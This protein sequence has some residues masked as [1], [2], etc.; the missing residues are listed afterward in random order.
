MASK[1][2]K[3]LIP[4]NTI[5]LYGME[6]GVIETFDLLRP[7]VKPH[8][9][10][11]HTTQRLSLP[12][13]AEVNG[14]R[15]DHSFFADFADWPRIERP[16][17]LLHAF[18]LLLTMIRGNLDVLR[19]SLQ[20]DVIYL[21]GIQYFYFAVLALFFHRFRRKKVIFHFHD[22]INYS[23]RRLRFASWFVTSFVH[24]SNLSLEVVTELNPFIAK[25][26]NTI[27]PYPVRT[28]YLLSSNGAF[29]FFRGRD[30]IIFLGQVSKHKGVDILLKAFDLLSKSHRNVTLHLVGGCDDPEMLA[31]LEAASPENECQIRYWG[32][33]AD[34]LDLLKMSDVYVHPSPPSRFHESFGL[35]VVEAMSVGVPPVCFKSG[36]L[37]EIVSHEETGLVCERETPESLEACLRR[38]L[39]NKSLRK[40]LGARAFKECSRRFDP[41]LVRSL[42]LALLRA[43]RS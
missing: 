22:L 6:R 38:L 28:L 41:A 26:S 11:S 40:A 4:F 39:T 43:H 2:V 8:F 16:R 42:W 5:S 33:R 3:V 17:S 24:N 21:S 35:G 10:M 27:I 15:L 1:P 9:L 12:V 34:G 25:K 18:N 31:Q 36:A 37:V 32:Y 30:N 13:L 23:S 14:R 7:D 29:E 19:A 20:I